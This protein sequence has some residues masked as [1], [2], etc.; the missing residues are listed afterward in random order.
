[1]QLQIVG[2]ENRLQMITVQGMG[3]SMVDELGGRSRWALIRP[4]GGRETR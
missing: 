2:D 4:W 3:L 1:M